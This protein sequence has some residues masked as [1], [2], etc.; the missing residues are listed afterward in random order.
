MNGQKG[1]RKKEW[2]ILSSDGLVDQF[3]EL[4]FADRPGDLINNI[5]VFEK[6]K[7]GYGTD[8]VFAR[9]RRI[10]VHIHLGNLDPSIEFRRQLIDNRSN[11]LARTA[12]W[13]PE[14]DE[15]GKVSLQD[16]GVKFIVGN[17]DHFI[18]CHD[19]FSFIVFSRTGSGHA[20]VNIFIGMGDKYVTSP[21]TL[22]CRACRDKEK[23]P[24]RSTRKEVKR[25][26]GKQDAGSC[27]NR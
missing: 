18:A 1:V 3:R 5:A 20:P 23:F 10:V 12:P 27:G 21:G 17:M 24:K 4:R 14:I 26:L 7:R 16:L 8:A 13:R 6:N 2:A 22:P 11:G 9:S 19:S 25:L 15:A